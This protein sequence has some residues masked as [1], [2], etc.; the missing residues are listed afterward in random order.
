MIDKRK[1]NTNLEEELSNLGCDIGGQ[2][3]A[4]LAGRRL[5]ESAFGGQAMGVIGAVGSAAPSE[6][7]PEWEAEDE[8]EED[9]DPI[10]GDFVT[11]ELLD[12]IE[13]LDM[14]EWGDYDECPATALLDGLR[15][16]DVDA[17]DPQLCERAERVV[18][19]LMEA[20]RAFLA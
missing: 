9:H 10:D 4:S 18:V 17:D 11:H 2:G 5:D 7:P 14:T 19:A 16:K 20:E 13:R 1:I 3:L 6:L 15:Q 8:V 12:R